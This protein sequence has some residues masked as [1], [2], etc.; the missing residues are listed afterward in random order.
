MY[1]GYGMHEIESTLKLRLDNEQTTRRERL[2]NRS[3][4]EKCHEKIS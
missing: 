3:H 1:P 4:M 2:E